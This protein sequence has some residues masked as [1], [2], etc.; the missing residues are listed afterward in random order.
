[1]NLRPHLALVCAAPRAAALSA[2]RAYFYGY[3]FSHGR[4]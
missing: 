1:M 2:V 3:W 4:A